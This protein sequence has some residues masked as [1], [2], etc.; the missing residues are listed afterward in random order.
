MINIVIDNMFYSIDG[1][2]DCE[3]PECCWNEACSQ[4]QYCSTVPEPAAILMR[5]PKLPEFAPFFEK[6]KFLV[7]HGSLQKFARLSEFD[8]Q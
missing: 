4:S 2:R 8:H 1:L 6:H 7:E 3:D 5:K